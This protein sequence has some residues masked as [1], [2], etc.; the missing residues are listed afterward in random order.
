MPYFA[1]VKR[2][3]DLAQQWPD[4]AEVRQMYSRERER[5]REREREREK[6]RER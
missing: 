4:L 6:E 3:K 5:A 1:V 2:L